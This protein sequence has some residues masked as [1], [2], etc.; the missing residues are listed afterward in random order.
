MSGFYFAWVA[1]SETTFDG[2]HQRVDEDVFAFRFEHKEGELPTWSVD[3]PNPRVGLLGPGRSTWAWLSWRDDE[4][5]YGAPGGVYP[6]AFGRL[7]G[8]PDNILGED[9]TLTFIYRPLNY[10]SEKQ[11]VA[12]TLKDFPYYDPLFIA[13][14][15]RDD[16]DTIIQARAAFWHVDR[17]SGAVTISDAIEGEDG[18][19]VFTADEVPYDSVS[20]QIG[21]PPLSQVR[22]DADV[23]WTQ[24][25]SGFVNVGTWSFSTYSGDGIVGD[26]PKALADLGGGWSAAYSVAHDVYR[27]NNT[28]SASRSYEWSNSA[29]SHSNGDVMSISYSS[30]EPNMPYGGLSGIV[31]ASGQNGVIDPFATDSAGDPAPLNIPE[32][33]TVQS[34]YVP[35]WLINTSLVAAYKA[36]RQMVEKCHVTVTAD[37]QA[38]VTDDGNSGDVKTISVSGGDVSQPIINVLNWSSLAGQ[39]VGLGQIIFPDASTTGQTAQVATTAGTAGTVPPSFSDVAGATTA[40]GS[41]IWASLGT[42]TAI[43]SAPDWRANANTPLGTIV[44]PRA[45]STI[46]YDWLVAQGLIDLPQTGTNVTLGTIVSAAGAYFICSTSG[47]TDPTS[48]AW[49]TGA[50]TTT[51]DGTAVWTSLGAVLPDGKTYFIATGGGVSGATTPA[52]N[53]TLGATTTDGSVVWTS[54]GGAEVPVGGNPGNTARGAYFP[55]DRGILSI[56]YLVCLGRAELRLSARAVQVTFE[57]DFERVLALSCRMNA[58]IEDPRL[59]GGTAAGKII[60]YTME[61][62]GDSGV[63]KSTVTIGCSIG[64]GGEI[65][66]T[67][68]T[69]DYV[70]S[71]YV[72]SGYQYT[73]GT[74]VPV[75]DV[76]FTPPVPGTGPDDIQFPLTA[77]NAVKLAVVHGDEATQAAA[78]TTAI[79]DASTAAGGLGYTQDYLVN[80][81]IQKQNETSADQLVR[82]ALKAVPIWLELELVN[83]TGGPFQ[84]DYFV[85][86]TPVAIAKTIDLE[87]A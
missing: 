64:V 34:I 72:A 40:D 41:V 62:D 61:G 1:S 35:R 77:A 28:T 11:R 16:P 39:A 50:G 53:T 12:E 49:S 67:D 23:T 55:S 4:G 86:T 19:E 73:G 31:T 17:I 82:D 14:D 46:P 60:A 44:L 65:T 20:M 42:T 85:N 6:I 80:N 83:L 3:I 74:I 21:Q 63:F 45:P 54:L 22:I 8:F 52:F 18:T 25:Y 48:P 51:A 59:P 56:G 32:T 75:S 78:V 30:S 15:K 68:G 27:I 29:R 5:R 76:G 69:P 47:T 10:R 84:S 66:T 71:E 87:A 13:A 37:T 26:W 81:T 9:I 38:I 43:T 36:D 57:C 24:A 79:A 70:A 2:S 33:A 7:V 58:T